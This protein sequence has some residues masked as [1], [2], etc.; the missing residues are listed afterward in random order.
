MYKL[1]FLLKKNMAEVQA[2]PWARVPV[3]ESAF[4]VRRRRGKER[5]RE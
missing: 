3:G 2:I 5:R 4:V 1:H